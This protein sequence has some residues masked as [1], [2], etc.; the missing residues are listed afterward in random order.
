MNT[1]RSY[2][3]IPKEVMAVGWDGTVAAMGADVRYQDKVLR[4]FIFTGR[5]DLDNQVFV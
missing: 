2:S 4:N 1:G 5:I 3:F